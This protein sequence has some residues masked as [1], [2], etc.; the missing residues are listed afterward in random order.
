MCTL[1]FIPKNNADFSLV[2]NRDESPKRETLLPEVYRLEAADC[3]F[4]KDALAGG[5]WIGL[6]NKQRA[7]CLLN[8]GFERH[9]IGTYGR[10]RGLLVLDLLQATEGEQLLESQDLAG[11]EPFTVVVIDWKDSLSLLECVWDGQEKHLQTLPIAPRIWSSRQLYTA[12]VAAK[13]EAWFTD[14]LNNNDSRL[15]S[16]LHFHRTAGDGDPQN[17][18]VMNRGFVRTKSISSIDKRADRVQFRYQELPEGAI[19]HHY[20]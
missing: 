6:S 8:G 2:S 16:Q 18:I 7:V 20:L 11:V 3:I 14:F 19:T 17:D 5:S 4:P 15:I 13:R 10:S 9:P 1:T 12:D